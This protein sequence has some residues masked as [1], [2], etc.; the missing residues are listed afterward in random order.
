MSMKKKRKVSHL[1]MSL[2]M[3]FENLE[4]D[5]NE[6]LPAWIANEDSPK[7]RAKKQIL[8]NMHPKA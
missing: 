3:F 2:C 8:Y 5:G 4:F 7:G 6:I 1:L